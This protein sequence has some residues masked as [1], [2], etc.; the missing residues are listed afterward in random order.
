MFYRAAGNL[1]FMRSTVPNG[2]ASLIQLEKVSLDVMGRLQ[3]EFSANFNFSISTD[4]SNT[5]AIPS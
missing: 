2:E 4:S 5:A 1:R 3:T